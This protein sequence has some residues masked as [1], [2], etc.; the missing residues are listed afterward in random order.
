MGAVELFDLSC[1]LVEFHMQTTTFP[2]SANSRLR[3]ARI[4]YLLIFM[5]YINDDCVFLH[6]QYGSTALFLAGRHGYLEV[7][8]LLLEAGARD[9]P[10]MVNSLLDQQ[11]ISL[12]ST[13]T[14]HSPE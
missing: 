12:F 2:F 14:S 1:Y 7:V 13:V 8:K 9:I 5:Y 10:T 6:T 11:H 4:S 3:L